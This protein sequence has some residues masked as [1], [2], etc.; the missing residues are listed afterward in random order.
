VIFSRAFLN[1]RMQGV[2]KMHLFDLHATVRVYAG[3]TGEPV[4]LVPALPYHCLDDPEI[5]CDPANDD[6]DTVLGSR[7]NTDCDD[8]FGALQN[9]C[10]QFVELQT[11]SD[12]EGVC[13]ALGAASI[14]REF[15][16]C[17]VEDL[18]IELRPQAG[19]YSADAN[20]STVLFGW[21]E[22]EPTG[23]TTMFDNTATEVWELQPPSL[24]EPVGPIGLRANLSAA[25]PQDPIVFNCTMGVDSI[26]P[27]ALG[28]TIISATPTPPERLLAV[29]ISR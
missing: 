8:P 1:E 17:V 16:S 26:D 18:E 25:F 4:T 15:K 7:G 28:P 3:A 11:S 27:E 2:V 13:E 6:G 24:V 21:E 19:L 9:P 12:C 20:A 5:T 23:A 29:P 22:G 10:G 14:C